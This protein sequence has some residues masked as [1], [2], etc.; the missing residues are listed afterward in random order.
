M[1]DNSAVTSDQFDSDDATISSVIKD[2][3]YSMLISSLKSKNEHCLFYSKEYSKNLKDELLKEIEST[4]MSLDK[5][6]LHCIISSLLPYCNT[7][8]KS[9]QDFLIEKINNLI[10]DQ[11]F[12][13]QDFCTKFYDL[14][15]YHPEEKQMYK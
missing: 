11:D 1:N 8:G 13:D 12:K 10:S 2:M 7:T 9:D 3:I 5:E 15:R 6:I 14:C 4:S